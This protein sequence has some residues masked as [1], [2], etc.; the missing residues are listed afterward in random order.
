LVS[1]LFSLNLLL[2][3]FNLLPF[4]PLDGASL[5]LLFLSES[6]AES[7]SEFT[8]QPMLS[9]VGLLIAWKVFPLIYWPLQ[10]GIET[11]LQHWL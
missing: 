7:Y 9:L 11:L 5:P 2:A 3:I 1:L 6:Q 4:P 8:R 10:S